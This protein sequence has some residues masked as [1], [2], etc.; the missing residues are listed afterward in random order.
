ME[1]FKKHQKEIIRVVG[2]LLLIAGFVINFWVTPQKAM[3][4]NEIAA[5]NLAR[6]QANVVGS[7]TKQ[8][9]KQVDTSH[10]SKALQATRKKQM[11]YLTIFSMILGALFLAYSFLKKEES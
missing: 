8:V 5:A 9:K 10:I 6:M 11:K 3:S 4:A 2:A 7:N 1:F